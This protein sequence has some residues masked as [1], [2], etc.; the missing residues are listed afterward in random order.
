MTA[1]A[2]F[3]VTN[4]GGIAVSNGTATV[5]GGPFTI[6]SGAT[7]GVSGL[8]STNVVV[9]FARV[10]R[11]GVHQQCGV[12][13]SQ[14]R[15]RHEHGDRRGSGCGGQLYRRS[16]QRY[17]PADRNFHRHVDRFDYQLVLNFGDGGTIN[18]ATNAVVYAYNTAGV[19]T[20]S[21]IVTAPAAPAPS[22]DPITSSY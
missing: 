7:F 9:Q 11:R 21:E 2:S 15:E 4:S 18:L 20:V 17:R 8:G 5:S 13:H 14:R 1:Q 22:P 10:V 12:H 3:V 19:Y 16:Y 6:V